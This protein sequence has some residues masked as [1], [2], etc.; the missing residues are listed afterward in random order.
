M[1][2]RLAAYWLG[3]VVIGGLVS[4]EDV[5]TSTLPGPYVP[6]PVKG[7]DGRRLLWEPKRGERQ[8]YRPDFSP[9]GSKLVVSYRFGSQA[10]AADLAI[11]DLNKGKVKVIVEGNCAKRPAWSPTGEWIAYQSDLDHAPYIWICKPDGS[12]HHRL[13]YKWAWTPRWSADGK[14]IYFTCSVNVREKDCG[15]YHD[16][17]DKELRTLYRDPLMH[18][19]PPVPSPGGEKVALWLFSNDENYV[20]INLAFI[21][22]DSTGFSAVWRGR[23]EYGWA[24]PI[25]WSPDG[26]YVLIWYGAPRSNQEGLWTY[27]VKN[28]VL[29]QITKCPPE[30]DFETILGASWG[31]NGD[32]VFA[33]EHGSLYLI[34]APE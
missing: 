22:P 10:R 12:E 7:D 5:P 31:P 34:K 30:V 32:I 16:F 33:S 17:N 3:L 1:W 4:C 14:R 28:S 25:D 21:D 9:Y 6:P 27:E 8:C 2:R 18:V 11:L 26:K 29:K 19:G 20:D 13:N 24:H 23:Y 15:V